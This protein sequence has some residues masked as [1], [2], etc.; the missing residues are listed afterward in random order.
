[1][2]KIY[3][4]FC[5]A[6]FAASC[7][8]FSASAADQVMSENPCSIPVQNMTVEQG[9]PDGS[10]YYRS[11]KQAVDLPGWGEELQ[12]ECIWEADVKFTREGA[13]FSLVSAD[14]QRFGTCVRALNRD[15]KLTLAMDG[16]TGSYYIWYQQV[17]PDTWY[18][19]KLIGKYGAADGMIDLV[20]D[21]YGADG[22]IVESKSYYV[23]LMNDMYASSGVGP[24]HIRVEPETCIDQVKVTKLCPDELRLKM[25]SDMVRQGSAVRIDLQT[26]RKGRPFGTAG[27]EA[28][29]GVTDGEGNPVDGVTVE[30]NLLKVD[31][32]VQPQNLLLKA[33][34]E[35]LKAEKEIQVV[36]EKPFDI[37]R[38]VFNE[39]Y[40]VLEELE[41]NKNGTYNGKAQMVGLLYDSDGLLQETL[42]KKVHGELIEEGKQTLPVNCSLPEWFEPETSRLQLGIWSG[43]EAE[44]SIEKGFFPL[45]QP[46]VIEEGQL[47]LP[48]RA[49]FEQ[50]GGSVEWLED[51][52]TVIALAGNQAAVFQI[53]NS[54]AFLAGD[55]SSMPVP[56]IIRDGYSYVPAE[57][58]AEM[59]HCTLSYDG[60]EIIVG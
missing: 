19:V 28:V 53:G 5:G 50:A 21:T 17:Q 24:E 37:L 45:T 6:V 22:Q 56:A 25:P 35:G 38:A 59:F 42:V 2:K 32:F 12:S 7:M 34:W 18:H 30:N 51:T 52:R 11:G 44:V 43:G 3:Q 60:N 1:M 47:L 26:L 33:E 39:E 16:G 29:Y 13:G 48:I 46:P 20:F 14:G 15:G 54:Q 27:A 55:R 23:I 40:T 9:A 31:G 10:S 58:L 4:I 49:F 8:V 36:P 41:L 57:C